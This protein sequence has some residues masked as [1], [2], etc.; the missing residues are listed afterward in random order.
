MLETYF[1]LTALVCA[2]RRAHDFCLYFS[3]FLL[4]LII[5]SVGHIFFISVVAASA[6]NVSWRYQVLILRT[7]G[8][9]TVV[10]R[11]PTHTHM[12]A[13]GIAVKLEQSQFTVRTIY[14]TQAICGVSSAITSL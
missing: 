12:H 2:H 6:M 5:P 10:K 7:C 11:T 14:P 8:Q 9:I 4:S 3:I 13:L 1:N